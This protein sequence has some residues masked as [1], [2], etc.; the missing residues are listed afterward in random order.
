MTPSRDTN[1]ETISLLTTSSLISFSVY[2]TTTNG[3]PRNRKRPL[4]FF[5]PSSNCRALDRQDSG[6]TCHGAAAGRA[7]SGVDRT[8][9]RLGQPVQEER[10]FGV[11]VREI[12]RGAVG[13]GG[14]GVAALALQGFDLTERGL[15][16]L[17]HRD[18]DG[19]V[20]SHHRRGPD[21]EQLVVEHED[22]GPVGLGM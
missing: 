2:T 8:A 1:S 16:S 17:H 9:R 22:L 3:P 5:A 14:L 6:R 15:G 13:R 7:P 20:E 12:E 11:V 19:P 18:G 10:P 4:V 21:F